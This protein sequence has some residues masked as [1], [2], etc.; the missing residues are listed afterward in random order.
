MVCRNF[1]LPEFC[2]PCLFLASFQ[3]AKLIV[4][5]REIAES[6]G[7]TLKQVKQLIKRQNNKAKKIANGYIPRSKGRPR[8]NGADEET[9]RSN[10]LVELRMQVELL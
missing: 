1:I 9:R 8:K 4:P 2:K 3:F 7:F 10:E 6:Y 5:Y